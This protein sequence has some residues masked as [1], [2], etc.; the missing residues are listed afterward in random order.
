MQQCNNANNSKSSLTQLKNTQNIV[1]TFTHYPFSMM[2]VAHRAQAG[3]ESRI[4]PENSLAAMELAI[5][6]GVAII[7]IDP[8]LTADG[9]YVLVHDETLDR[10]TNVQA[11]FPELREKSGAFAG[12]VLVSKLTLEQI[13][14][15]Q[16]TD[17][18]DGQI[19]R[20]PTLREALALAKDRVFLDLDLKEIDIDKLATLVEEF[21]KENLLAYNSNAEKLKEVTDKTGIIPLPINTPIAKGGNPIADFHQFQKMWGE[22]FKIMHTFMSDMTPELAA[23]ADKHKVRLWINTLNDADGAAERF[24]YSLWNSYLNSG[25]NVF[26][27]DL[28]IELTRF[29]HFRHFCLGLQTVKSCEVFVN[30]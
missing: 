26:Q 28:A 19:H 1:K 30:P 16:L 8:R 9:H 23:L 5:N 3:V 13:K 10:T 14:Q 27:S 17:G 21:G 11:V 6:R 29:I 7:E 25:A 22:D 4:F 2:T 24:D 20:V 15:L 18:F 12:K